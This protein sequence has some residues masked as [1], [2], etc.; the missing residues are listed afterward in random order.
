MSS[1]DSSDGYMSEKL[2]EESGDEFMSESVI[3]SEL[4]QEMIDAIIFRVSGNVSSVMLKQREKDRE[5]KRKLREN[6]QNE[7]RLIAQNNTRSL[8]A[9]IRDNKS[10]RDEIISGLSK[11]KETFI[12]NVWYAASEILKGAALIS[13]IWYF[14]KSDRTR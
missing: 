14:W 2:K 1:S 7:R 10:F 6:W 11:P 5:E 8:E 12:S 3:R 13:A 9:V 4:D